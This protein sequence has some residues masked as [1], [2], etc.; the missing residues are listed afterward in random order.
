MNSLIV[1]M[2]EIGK[3]VK[4]VITKDKIVTYDSSEGDFNKLSDPDILHICFPY[5]ENFIKEVNGYINTIK[6]WHVIIWS[7]L[8]IG[9]TKRINGAVHSPVEGKHPH[10]ASSIM[11][12]VRWI[13]SNDSFEGKFFKDYFADKLLKTHVVNNS[14]FT[15]ALKLLSTTEY[16]INIEFARYKKQ[17]A[18]AIGMNYELTKAWNK[19]YNQ[20]YK[21]HKMDDRFQKFVLD[22]P[23]GKIGG[24]CVVPNAKLLDKQYPNELVKIVKGEE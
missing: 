20:L 10:L 22:A 2:G 17:V 24:H 4:K 3:A 11:N 19:D 21:N 18:D 6:P 23:E 14:D 9:T 1:G 16:G 12:S 15:E 5:S 13:G 7:T 8:P